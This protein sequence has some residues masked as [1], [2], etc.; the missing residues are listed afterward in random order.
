MSPPRPPS[1]HAAAPDVDLRDQV[2]LVTGATGF[3]GRHLTRRLRELGAR[4][5]A[6]SRRDT[7]P[8][9]DRALQWHT[10][11]LTDAEAAAALVATVRPDVILHL[12]S[13]VEGRR[14]HDLVLP[15]LEANTHAAIALM[16][17][18]HVL[19]ACRVVLAGSIEE[20]RDGDAPVSPYAAAKHATTGYAQLFNSQWDLVVTVLR[21]AMVYGPD[22]PDTSKLVPYSIGC[23]LD[24]HAPTVG[25]GTRPIDWV[26]VDDVVEAFLRAATSHHAA[27]LVAD[28]GTGEAHTVG[29]VVTA[30]AE[31]TGHRDHVDFGQRA[32]R[33]DESAHIADPST[34][35]DALGWRAEID[36]ATGLA[37]TVDWYRR[38]RPLLPAT[39]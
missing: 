23:F 1:D 5:H 35:L 38:H 26:Y 30:I 36:L 37:R 24:G 19:P 7:G 2:V 15:M 16:E 9:L 32:D 11:D 13:R 17:A 25:S 27:G 14:E 29:E 8:R 21:I 18:A 3:I 20:P 33:R 6:T 31:L 22:Q 39:G 12:A 10:C 4:V 28:I 34:A